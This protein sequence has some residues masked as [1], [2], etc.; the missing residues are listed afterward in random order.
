MTVAIPSTIPLRREPEQASAEPAAEIAWMGVFVLLVLL[1][2]VAWRKRRNGAVMPD[3]ANADGF[4]SRWTAGI[5]FRQ[6]RPV[7]LVSSTRLTTQHSMHEV[8]WQGRRLLI[9]CAP[10]SVALIAEV[11]SDEAAPTPTPAPVAP[12]AN[13]ESAR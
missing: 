2:F 11:P 9:G 3:A 8:V 1:A 4:W 7:Q 13:G 12:A 5:P 6:S 10:Q